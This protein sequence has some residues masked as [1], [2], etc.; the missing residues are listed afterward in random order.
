[1]YRWDVPRWLPW[2]ITLMKV[3]SRLPIMSPWP[4]NEKFLYPSY[5]ETLFPVFFGKIGG[6]TEIEYFEQVL[7]LRNNSTIW[8][9]KFRF[10]RF[11]MDTWY[12]V[13]LVTHL[14]WPG[15]FENF[16]AFS[17]LQ[18]IQ[19][20]SSRNSRE[21]KWLILWQATVEYLEKENL[22][23][24]PHV[25]IGM[26]QCLNWLLSWKKNLIA[27]PSLWSDYMDIETIKVF[28]NSYHGGTDQT[29][30]LFWPAEALKKRL[31]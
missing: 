23:C 13:S 24:P 25:S 2:S 26:F 18:Q 20:E 11:V 10:N 17:S 16:L 31:C 1:M 7:V 27:I 8:L 28:G 4:I 15:F 3:P 30:C 6:L 29:S 14:N 19:V 22:V 12:L 9:M 21:L 5:K